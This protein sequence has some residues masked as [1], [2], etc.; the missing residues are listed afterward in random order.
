M[1]NGSRRGFLTAACA[2]LLY[3]AR[4]GAAADVPASTR[5]RVGLLLPLSSPAFQRAAESVRQGFLAAAQIDPSEP[6][7]IVVYSTTDDPASIAAGYDQALAEGARL[8]VGPLTRNGVSSIL[9]RAKPGIRLLALNV[10]EEDVALPADAYSFSLQLETDARQIARMAYEDGRRNA[11]VLS[12]TPPLAQRIHRAFVEEFTRLGGRISAQFV[13]RSTTADLLALREAAAS[14]QSDMAFLALDG[15]RARIVRG[16][17]DGPLNLYAT[18]QVLEGAPDRLRDADL[19]GIRFV[20]MPW[21]LQADHPAVMTYS[22]SPNAL[23]AATDFERLYAFGIDAYR[24]AADLAR[25]AEAAGAALDGVTGR[26]SLDKDHHFVRELTA[27]QFIDGQPV[28][29]A[30]R[31]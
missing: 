29:I 10:P 21:L 7:D 3:G 19:N 1:L 30:S 25:N 27:A 18:S 24:L 16:Y 23:P 8:V 14:G 5:P 9:L 2:T 17:L 22:R 20:G 28:I 26:I 15:A 11:L 4:I 31:P 6:L 13:Y 12:D